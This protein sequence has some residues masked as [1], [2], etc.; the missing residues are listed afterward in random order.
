MP[1]E[2]PNRAWR[3]QASSSPVVGGGKRAWQQGGA[4][5]ATTKKPW[6]KKA[7]LG[8]SLG[9]LA[10]V[11][12]GIGFLLWL[13]QPIKPACLILIGS[14]Y[15]ED[16]AVPPNV[17]GW[18]GLQDLADCADKTGFVESWLP[19]SHAGA[20][21]LAHGP[22]ALEEKE[23]QSWKKIWENLAL[24]FREKTVIVYLALHGAADSKG[25]YLMLN[26]AK[27]RERVSIKQILQDLGS[28]KLE[29]KKKL[30]ILDATQ[31]ATHWPGGVLH[32]DFARQLRELEKEI[33][34]Q[35]NLVVFCASDVD[36][37]SWVSEEWQRTIFGHYVVE[38][39][40]GAAA[41]ANLRVTAQGLAGYVRKKVAAWAQANRNAVQTP[42]L[43]G[44]ESRAGDIE[45][46]QVTEA[47]TEHA[48]EQAP[49]AT[50]T[51]PRDLEAAWE[52]CRQL[53]A[54]VPAPAVYSPQL[55]RRY[56]DALVR[57]EHLIRA[58]EAT[59]KAPTL[60][61]HL[62]ALELEIL[63]TR[64]LDV[65]ASLSNTLAMPAMM[66]HR[67]PA[68]DEQLGPLVRELW[69][70]KTPQRQQIAWQKILELAK[71]SET[72]ESARRL[73]QVQL[74]K[75]LLEFSAD[76]KSLT[77][78]ELFDPP[79]K[80]AERKGRVALDWF[81]KLGSLHPAEGQYLDLL[82]R[83]FDV[84]S[85]P[86]V[87]LIQQALKVRVQ[88]E[89]TALSVAKSPAPVHP[90]SEAVLPW[91]RQAV[92]AAD[93]QRRFGEDWLLGSTSEARKEARGQL[94]KAQSAYTAVQADAAV[95]RQALAARDRALDE[96][97][98]Y[99][100]WLA[101]Q[102]PTSSAA[103]SDQ[104]RKIQ[105][106]FD[107][108]E[109]VSRNVVA[110][111][112]RLD[113]VEPKPEVFKQLRDLTAQI[114]SD[115]DGTNEKPGIRLVFQ[116]I[117]EK[118]QSLDHQEIWHDIQA[119]T[120]CP[121]IE[122]ASLRRALV[123]NSRRRSNKLNTGEFKF[124][125]NPGAKLDLANNAKDASQRQRRMA[126]AVL[127]LGGHSSAESAEGSWRERIAESG[128]QIAKSWEQLHDDIRKGLDALPKTGKLD[129]AKRDL[130]DPEYFTRIVPG[131]MFDL[132]SGNPA[133]ALRRLR[134]HDVLVW[135]ARRAI[136]D[137]YF[138]DGEDPR[139]T[140]YEP[141]AR[142][143]LRDAS[144]LVE[145]ASDADLS[146]DRL[147]LVS[148]VEKQELLPARLIAKGRATQPVTTERQFKVEWEIARDGPVP[149][150]VPMFWLGLD[151]RLKA[152]NL[153]LPAARKP[154]TGAQK[155]WYV[156]DKP[157]ENGDAAAVLHGVF[158]GQRLAPRTNL[159]V[160]Q[161]ADV[162]AHRFPRPK[163]AA[164]AM[165]MKN[166]TYGAISIV[167]DA[168]GSMGYK[169]PSDKQGNKT[170]AKPN[171]RID[172][173]LK[174]LETVLD[175]IPNGTIVS[176][177]AIVTK[178]GADRSSYEPL[179]QPAAWN[180]ERELPSLMGQLLKL[181]PSGSSPIARA[182]VRARDEGF[183][184]PSV[185]KGPKV[186]LVFTDGDDTE[187]VPGYGN[188]GFN[189]RIS[190]FLGEQFT[191]PEAKGIEVNVVCFNDGGNKDAQDEARN[192][193][194]QFK[195]IESLDTPGRFEPQPK[196][197]DD[198]AKS[199]EEAIRPRLRLYQNNRRAPGFPEKGV[200]VSRDG[201]FQPW[202][203]AP[204]TY[205]ATV[206]HHLKQ[207]IEARGGEVLQITLRGGKQEPF[208]RYLFGKETGLASVL[209][210]DWHVSALQNQIL[211]KEK[212]LRQLITFE[213]RFVAPGAGGI[214]RHE[215]P[216]FVWLEVKAKGEKQP[217]QLVWHNEYWHRAPAYRL[218]RE[219]W[220]GQ[221]PAW[222]APEVSAWPVAQKFPAD[223]RFAR[224]LETISFDT[225][226]PV[227]R[228]S[229]PLTIREVKVE[230]LPVV[231]EPGKT[232]ERREMRKCVVVRSS[233]PLDRP[234]WI[235]ADRLDYEGEE[236]HYY[237][238]SGEYTA[239]FWGV[240]NTAGYQLNVIS[241]HDLKTAVEPAR[242]QL[243]RPRGDDTGPE[244]LNVQG[245]N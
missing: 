155:V 19:W 117:C 119:A 152:G 58:G 171:R 75:K 49:G 245:T 47:Y 90:Y 21:R 174:A 185:Y 33:E 173:A 131:G 241:L 127:N 17:Y 42:F 148:Q 107:K 167:F 232:P 1:A 78:A 209:S 84:D 59:K 194:E 120:A 121:L 156:L 113:N 196:G 72:D 130:K 9:A 140:Y 163:D 88:A 55:W 79:G 71:A 110:L 242:L 24:N 200:L 231:I 3:Q 45:L 164:V 93:R 10:V 182:M 169:F 37:R 191:A 244:P 48:P 126:R 92:E 135:Q 159:Q 111:R 20:M 227:G 236:H 184:V 161:A 225:P 147:A 202:I 115:L 143:Y 85:E 239:I 192:A 94:D 116:G 178:P 8:F 57:Y 122:T 218:R 238:R 26:D 146:N 138:A 186:I 145:I 234:F 175:G 187:S 211:R 89:Q 38:G 70:A 136:A 86:A 224:R 30:L 100:E 106:L 25:A 217:G 176:L 34:D 91:I 16:L 27:G 54:A 128:E 31:I 6:S 15:A 103:Q 56:Q 223:D 43:L 222:E 81:K 108:V 11:L 199:L 40:K 166:V 206:Q 219:S 221:D 76:H 112:H 39:L 216:E 215:P 99:A 243:E 14:D 53:R 193:L 105:A 12:G 77:H 29:N 157:A 125:V 142:A 235:Q 124:E 123:E 190:Q 139:A 68:S 183:P 7:K 213:D 237:A 168:S 154:L 46:V 44:G 82:L 207:Q 197:G 172:F 165:W 240:S 118:L 180:K 22:Q 74:T 80:E 228:D 203:I 198:L 65:T 230:D 149:D 204:G 212:Q 60:K 195:I 63:K 5:A 69:D 129:E 28:P 153:K 141:A 96:L 160:Y 226:I 151:E 229:V 95:V 109:N 73:M 64:R 150:G 32:N 102:R 97:P 98:Y 35:P 67:L 50:F 205:E 18:K 233:H 52:K 83:D 189:K 2:Q 220:S 66:G 13:L 41:D 179:R 101:R 23:S 214:M 134:T 158:R 181:N 51:Y 201:V 188:A 104:Q 170:T 162:I 36:E 132:T 4:Q 61:R 133:D 62:D 210:R 144:K 177:F 114:E 137:H 87:A 208:E